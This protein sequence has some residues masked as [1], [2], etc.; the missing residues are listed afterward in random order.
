MSTTTESQV[1]VT[2]ALPYDVASV[3][4]RA[5][6][7]VELL[8]KIS[9]LGAI[10]GAIYCVTREIRDHQDVLE[11]SYELFSSANQEKGTV[12]A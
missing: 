1:E 9:E 4:L 2:L 8:E 10:H 6:S 11:E 7:T 3:T 5:E 12:S